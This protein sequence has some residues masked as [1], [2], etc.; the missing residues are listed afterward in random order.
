MSSEDDVEEYN[1][2]Y[3]DKGHIVS[4]EGFDLPKGLEYL[5]NSLEGSIEE[6][7]FKN[8]ERIFKYNAKMKISYIDLKLALKNYHLY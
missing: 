1:W 8:K 6:E 3:G 7:T 5:R 4:P 2:V